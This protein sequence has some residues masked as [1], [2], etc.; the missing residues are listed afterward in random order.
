MLVRI[1]KEQVLSG[2]QK[3]AGIIPMKTGA[4]FL[5]TIWLEAK[6]NHLTIMSTDS[7]LE[8]SGSYPA[9]V[10][11]PGLIGV[12]GKKFYD[13][14]RKLP[15]GEITLHAADSEDH[16]LLE[17]GRRKY[18][19]PTND[20][21]WFQPFS[22]FPEDEAVLW[23]G[24]FLKE[25][26]NRI[27]YCVADDESMNGMNCLK[28]TP[29][30]NSEAVEAC[31][32]NGHQFALM[33][34]LNPDIHAILPQD[35]EGEDS[36]ILIAKNYLLEL[37]KWLSSDEIYFTIDQKRLFFTNGKKNEIFSLPLSTYKFPKYETFLSNFQNE[38]SKL[39]IG[40]DEILD[41]LERVALFNTENQRCSYFVFDSTEM[42]VYSQGQETGEATE[43]LGVEY[44][45]DLK[46]IA[47]P[48][49]TLIEV[50][51]HF[52]SEMIT[53]EFT[54]VEGPCKITGKEDSGYL[55]VVMPM[56]VAEETYYVEEE[57]END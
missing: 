20:A 15:P 39:N 6:D 3:A 33:R 40:R 17:Q 14:F 19:L 53:F 2:F 23:S 25:I 54:G 50:L 51:S 56:H 32:L 21:S 12:P 31:G 47:F 37:K 34:F 9:Q 27:T 16:V 57:T 22:A 10:E 43:S 36:G 1:S 29:W 49:T 28:I 30:P 45:G 7:K 11:T 35:D 48:T 46:K 5:R 26:I 42:I 41:A 4:A 18:K 52:Q 24:D 8:F 44:S 13:L 55:V 38:T